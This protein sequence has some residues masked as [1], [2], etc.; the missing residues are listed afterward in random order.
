MQTDICIIGAGPAGVFAA[1]FAAQSG[2]KVLIVERNTS[3]CRKLLRTGRTEVPSNHALLADIGGNGVIVV[4]IFFRQHFLDQIA[5]ELAGVAL[6]TDADG[7]LMKL[8]T[9]LRRVLT[10]GRP[11]SESPA[12]SL[13]AAGSDD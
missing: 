9:E 12:E 1:I 4:A 13:S 2:A 8:D 7:Q 5:D 11:I 6:G 3:A 10:V